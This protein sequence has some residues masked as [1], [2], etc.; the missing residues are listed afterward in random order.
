MIE[1]ITDDELS[2]MESLYNPI[3]FTECMFSNLEGPNLAEF[4]KDKFSH[5]RLYQFPMLSFEYLVDYERNDLTLK[6]NFKLREKSGSVIGFGARRYGKSLCVE[7]ID[8]P[9]DMVLN[10][11][12]NIGFTSYDAAHIEGMLETIILAF[13]NHPFLKIFDARI[14][15]NPYLIY[16][17]KNRSRVIGINMNLQ[18]PDPGNNFYQKHFSRLYVEEASQE[19]QAVYDKRIDSISELGCVI[20]M[21]GMCNFTKYSPAGKVFYDLDNKALIVNY[22][23]FVNPQWDEKEREEAIKKRGGEDSAGYRIFVK[24]EVVEDAVSVM[25]MEKIRKN[26]NPKK[27]LKEFEVSKEKFNDFEN[28]LILERPKNAE[29]LYICSDIGESA[30]TEIIILSQVNNSFKYTH[31]ITLHN[32]TDKEQAKIFKHLGFMLE[33]NFIGLDTTDGTG[34]SI[35]HSLEESFSRKNLGWVHFSEKIPVDIEKDDKGNMV[36]KDGLPVYREEY[37]EAWSIKRLKDLLYEEGRMELPLQYK[38][39]SQLNSVIAVHSGNRI[40]YQTVSTEDHLLAAFRVF[41]I[42]QWQNEF[43]NTPKITKKEFSKTGA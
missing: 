37:V 36:F 21:S 4:D 43:V 20:R 26:Y 5:I 42:T 32:L 34:R 14:K 15:R 9:M 23:Q 19:T 30:P 41:A 6:E 10:E 8:L 16:L 22:P 17:K 12:E 27:I 1:R 29:Y 3:C 28:I 13:E 25:D 31:N 24:G 11:G 18:G 35:F 7:E 39:D 33:A 2:F 38:L 40:T